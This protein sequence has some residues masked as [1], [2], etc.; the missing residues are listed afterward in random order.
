MP[1]NM[2]REDGRN[3]VMRLAVLDAN[4]ARKRKQVPRV[5]QYRFGDRAET[6]SPESSPH[7]RGPGPSVPTPAYIW[8]ATATIQVG[9]QDRQHG[10]QRGPARRLLRAFRFLVHGEA[11][12]PAPEREDGPEPSWTMNADL[13]STWLG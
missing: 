12:V 4:T 10:Q 11:G 9:Q 1:S 13:G 2:V 3:V 6:R 5:A 8:V 7:C